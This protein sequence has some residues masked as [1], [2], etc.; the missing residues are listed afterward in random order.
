[1]IYG[2]MNYELDTK[3]YELRRGLERVPI[4]PQVY[5]VL[6]YLVAH[7]D[8]VVSKDELL[9]QL[10]SDRRVSESTL[11]H[12]VMLARKAL[13]DDGESQRCIRTLRRRGYRFV[14]TLASRAL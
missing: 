2:F 13:G 3:L 14:A 8:R 12:C 11:S 7:H 10:W 9:E 4:E 6:A 1:M 5:D